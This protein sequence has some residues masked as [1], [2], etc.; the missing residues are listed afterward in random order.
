[1]IIVKLSGGLGN[2]LF[3]YV[4]GLKWAR[5][6]GVSL[7]IDLSS[8]NKEVTGITSRPFVL[9][10]FN[11]E[12]EEATSP[13][14]RVI[15]IPLSRNPSILGNI[16]NKVIQNTQSRYIIQNGMLDLYQNEVIPNNSYLDGYW[17]GKYA[18]E[19]LW[20]NLESTLKVKPKY[21]LPSECNSEIQNSNSVCIHIR[22]GDYITSNMFL[23][24]IN[25]F[26][27]AITEMEQRR[28]EPLHFFI[29]S[30]DIKWCRTMLSSFIKERALE[31]T[32]ISNNVPKGKHDINHFHLMT[33]CKHFIISN[34]TFSWWA[35]KL[36]TY[37]QK[38]IICPNQFEA[39]NT[40]HPHLILD[41][42]IPI[43]IQ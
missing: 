33:C 22:R 26:T 27:R 16:W 7:K 11:L 8:F 43:I 12:L 5:Y 39:T 29:F 35:A 13:D 6:H 25:Y 9:N 24:P 42:W 19:E 34:S 31:F 14:F 23:L 41:H 17:I 10:F 3:Q 2:Q 36:G 4:F 38:V 15:K 21:L 20:G 37:S 30:D 1:M 18:V 32:F 40:Q 28:S